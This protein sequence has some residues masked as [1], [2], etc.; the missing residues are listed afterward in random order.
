MTRPQGQAESLLEGLR[1]LGA[2]ALSYPTIRIVEPS[3][4]APLRQAVADLPAYDWLVFTSANGVERFWAGLEAADIARLPD[5]ARV[6]AIGPATADALAERGVEAE[7]VPEEYVAEAVAEALQ[8]RAELADARILLPRAAGARKVLPERLR[9]AGARVDEVV[10]YESAP[11]AEGIE[12]L[13][14][15]IERDE[16]D[17]VTF[18]A[19]STVRSYV[20]TAGPDLGSARVAVIGPITASAARDAGLQVDV[21]ALEYTVPGLLQAIARYYG[22]EQEES[23]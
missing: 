19:A 16:V 20:D 21:E 8:S 14:G 5:E 3:D 2:R 18:T 1:Q 12:A 6:A 17:M 15:A 7:I 22:R 11:D 23:S 9:A 13:R 4:P 10:A